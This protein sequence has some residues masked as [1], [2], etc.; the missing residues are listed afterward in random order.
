MLNPYEVLGLSR[1]AETK[2][3]KATYRILSAKYHPDKKGGS[4]EKFEELKLAHDILTDPARRKRYDTTGRTDNS[5][6]NAERMRDYIE[7]T[8]KTVVE[9]ERSDG[10]ADDPVFINIRDKILAQIIASRAIMRNDRYKI[11][12][13][14]ERTVRM[15]ERFKPTCDFDPV[16]DALRAEKGRLEHELVLNQDALEISMEAE[17]IFK[18]YQYEVGPGPEGHFSPGPTRPQRGPLSLPHH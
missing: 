11:E 17:R 13:K 7:G 3:I 16:G 1:N 12:R 2:Q 9:A 15:L 8:M 4:R 18:T 14:L 6:I 10:S 5:P